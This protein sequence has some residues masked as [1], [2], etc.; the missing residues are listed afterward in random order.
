LLPINIKRTF[1]LD[2]YPEKL[3]WR[4]ETIRIAT[5]SGSAQQNNNTEKALALIHDELNKIEVVDFIEVLPRQMKLAIPGSD[6]ALL[7]RTLRDMDGIILATP[8]YHG[9]FS[10]LMKMTI[11]NLGYPSALK[12]KPIDLLGVSGGSI[13]AVKSLEHLRS[14]CAHVGGLVLPGSVS[15][16]NIRD[17]FDKIG[18]CVP[19]LARKV[20]TFFHLSLRIPDRRLIPH[21]LVLKQA[22]KCHRQF[23]VTTTIVQEFSNISSGSNPWLRYKC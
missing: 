10:S 18:K 11:E 9:S 14:V 23:S 20:C 5:I 19:I 2:F 6:R 7:Q 8:E 22:G 4:N 16:P 21:P 13:G 17:V 3:Y 1:K 15:I 12:G